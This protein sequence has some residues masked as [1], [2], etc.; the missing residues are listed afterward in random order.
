MKI[1]N[2]YPPNYKTIVQV[3]PKVAQIETIVFTYG[4]TLYNPA[5]GDISADLMAHESVHA[6]QQGSNPE[7]WWQRYLADPEFRFHQE[8]VAYQKQYKY[9]Q[10]HYTRR[11]KILVLDHIANSIAGGMYGERYTYKEAK[12]MIKNG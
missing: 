9:A 12:E 3:I 2:N 5:G 11:S 7:A 1:S 4:D 10:K 6:D 8:K